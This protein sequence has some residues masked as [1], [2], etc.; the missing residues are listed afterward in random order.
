MNSHKKRKYV[1]SIL[2]GLLAVFV[3]FCGALAIA[4]DE[5]AAGKK[6]EKMAW[7]MERAEKRL[8][9]DWFSRAYWYT[10]EA[11]KLDSNNTEAQEMLARIREEE[12][13]YNKEK[14]LVKEEKDAP[15]KQ[16]KEAREQARKL[17]QEQKEA[18]KINGYLEKADT[19]LG[20]NKYSS[21][22]R[23]AKAAIKVDEKNQAA[24][25]MLTKVDQAEQAYNEEKKR[26]KDQEETEERT[27]KIN[28]YLSKAGTY[29]KNGKFSSARRYAEKA[30]KV[31]G[32]NQET[33]EMLERIDKR[34]EETYQKEQEAL[35]AAETKKERSKVQRSADKAVKDMAKDEAKWKRIEEKVD[36]YI[37]KSREALTKKDYQNAKRFA[38]LARKLDPTS[39]KVAVLVTEITKEEMFGPRL[40]QEKDRGERIEAAIAEAEEPDPFDSFNEKQSWFEYVTDSLRKRTYKLGY[41]PEEK[42]YTIDDCVHIALKRSQRKIVSDRQVKLAEMRMWEA[43]RDLLP[44]VTV[45]LEQTF[46]KIGQT[47]GTRHYQ[48]EKHK[49]EMK[50]TA[51]DGMESWTN[52]EQSQSNLEIVKLEREKIKNEIIAETKIAYFNLD[53]AIKALD[54]QKRLKEDV[55]SLYDIIEK[56]YQQELVARV[57]YLKVKGQNLQAD[58]QYIS[59]GE[60]ISLAELILYQAM[61][62]E[63]DQ[64][65]KIK[66]VKRIGEPVSVGLENCYR[67]AEANRPDF[68]AKVKTIEYYYF[69][70]KMMRGR[71]WPK[72]TFHGSFGESVENFQ[73]TTTVDGGRD[74]EPEWFAGVKGTFPAWGNTIE[75]NYVTEKWAPGYSDFQGYLGFGSETH[76]SYFNI[77]VLDDLAYFSNLQESRA[78]FENAKYEYLKAKK[79]LTVEVKETYFKYRKSLLQI[80]VAK[81]KVEHQKSY[82]RVLEERLRFGEGET[83][84]LIEEREKLAGDEYGIISGNATYFISLTELNKAIGVP[85]YFRTEFEDEEYNKWKDELEQK[86]EAKK[87]LADVKEDKKN[88]NATKTG[89]KTADD[90]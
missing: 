77:K 16:K 64:P 41:V 75:Y 72:I 52:V 33:K 83:S 35:K 12:K 49:V 11:L 80:D 60:D 51:F 36:K 66:Q 53:K 22:R 82:V 78:G 2:I 84:K 58:F 70:R 10:N 62:M 20:K 39:S 23:Y 54:V 85:G 34:V 71:G 68:Q 63:P 57:E 67:L 56:A 8:N 1:K 9:E 14:G 27:E 42:V 73:P 43:R 37:E 86:K 38:Y 19:Y 44:E 65:I 90:Q 21:A 13:V 74:F 69:D 87:L 5:E 3:F 88:K 48:G 47:V 17:E 81:A 31:D 18:K 24:Q 4:E 25:A 30:L 26:L 7:Y 15:A 32:D 29:L 79:D 50:Y 6:A 59:A 89:S 61:N 55:N 45:R 46:G 40:E 28:G 76:T